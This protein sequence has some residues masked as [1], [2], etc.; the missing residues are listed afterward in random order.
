MSWIPSLEA[1]C[2]VTPEQCDA[3]ET[4]IVPRARDIGSFE[5]RRALPSVRRGAIRA[6]PA[7]GIE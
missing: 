2:P 5:V 3:I 6:H 4:L 7:V 1:D